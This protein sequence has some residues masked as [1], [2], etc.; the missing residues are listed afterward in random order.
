MTE[1]TT[2]EEARAAGLKR[3]FPGKP[4][5]R[6][7]V[8]E[9]KASD[10]SCVECNRENNRQRRAADPEKHRNTERRRRTANR[11]AANEKQRRWSE[12]N[13]EKIREINRRW[14]AANPNYHRERYANDP[15]LREKERKRVRQWQAD[16]PEYFRQ[17]MRDRYANDPE[18][19]EKRILRGM[20]E[21]ITRG[22]AGEG[23]LR[24]LPPGRSDAIRAKIETDLAA[25]PDAPD[26]FD[27]LD[28]GEWHLDHVVPLSVM[29]AM[30]PN[31]PRPVLAYVATHPDML[32]PLPATE[33][34]SRGNRLD[35][36]AEA[37]FNRFG[38]I[39][40]EARAYHGAVPQAA[41]R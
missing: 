10:G 27:D 33:N 28:R 25:I 21:R 15:E 14:R 22:T 29:L 9:R 41:K 39:V 37:T 40:D 12:K 16:N 20:V 8:A 24:Y 1:I 7:H 32:R 18:F 35:A 31:E 3:Y 5:R 19:R 26:N 6:G 2:R 34:I 17:Y 4:C 13:P 38:E 30:L 23:A 36:D 11:D